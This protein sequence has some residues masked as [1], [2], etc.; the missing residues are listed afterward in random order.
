MNTDLRT[1]LPGAV[2]LSKLL[3]QKDP[4]DASN[5]VALA[6]KGAFSPPLDDSPL[7]D[8]PGRAVDLSTE[9]QAVIG[10][11]TAERSNVTPSGDTVFQR[12]LLKLIQ[13]I[14]GLKGAILFHNDLY[15]MNTGAMKA[16]AVREEWL[17]L[18][19][20][21]AVSLNTLNAEWKAISEVFHARTTEIKRATADAEIELAILSALLEGN[22]GWRGTSY[23]IPPLL[24]QSKG[25][26]TRRL[27]TYQYDTNQSGS[28][29]ID[30]KAKYQDH[31]DLLLEFACLKEEATAVFE[32]LKGHREAAC[33][34][35]WAQKYYGYLVKELKDLQTKRDSYDQ[36]ST[37]RITT[38]GEE[39]T[40]LDESNSDHDANIKAHKKE[41]AELR[42]HSESIAECEKTLTSLVSNYQ[43]TFRFQDSDNSDELED[44]SEVHTNAHNL[45]TTIVS[46]REQVRRSDSLTVCLERK[47]SEA[48]YHHEHAR[49]AYLTAEL[50]KFKTNQLPHRSQ[51]LKA[52]IDAYSASVQLISFGSVTVEKNLAEIDSALQ[53]RSK[54]QV[55]PPRESKGMFAYLFSAKAGEKKE[56]SH[57]DVTAVAGKEDSQT[58][59]E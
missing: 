2:I 56:S 44:L 22:T 9:V 7:E 36:T 49:F 45:L 14:S 26:L 21:E 42:Y 23:G 17:A 6:A 13:T 31:H 55:D 30:E 47:E 28:G 8:L 25:E 41:L 57:Q 54:W 11:L 40:S 46:L 18:R 12:E 38:I 50:E 24:E 16:P 51:Q 19:D 20:R 29:Q 53:V 4:S 43:K 15:P 52:A 58:G 10:K 1:P 37:K 34:S 48:A 3:E 27:R 33:N 59:D 39:L 5:P 32:A 35:S